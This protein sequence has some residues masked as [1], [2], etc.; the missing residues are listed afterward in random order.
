MLPLLT[1]GV[2]ESIIDLLLRTTALRLSAAARGVGI[3]RRG[4]ASLKEE[5]FFISGFEE[6]LQ[7]FEKKIHILAKYELFGWF[8]N[9]LIEKKMLMISCS[10]DDLYFHSSQHDTC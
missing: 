9:D 4:G 5:K 2:V 1:V 3:R 8:E 10:L 7:V 6:L